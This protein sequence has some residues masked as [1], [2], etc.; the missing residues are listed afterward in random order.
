M[1]IGRSVYE[2]YSAVKNAANSDEELPA[3][4]KRARELY[5]YLRSAAPE[6]SISGAAGELRSTRT[7]EKR[8]EL[9]RQRQVERERRLA[10][11]A[12]GDAVAE[13]ERVE[14]P[15]SSEKDPEVKAGRPPGPG[16]EAVERGRAAGLDPRGVPGAR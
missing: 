10:S 3:V 14:E 9:E 8:I 7:E 13:D 11:D 15:G 5:D 2:S 6:F 4:K 1:D 12:G 16:A